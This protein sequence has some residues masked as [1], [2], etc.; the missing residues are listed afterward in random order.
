MPTPIIPTCFATVRMVDLD[1]RHTHH[2]IFEESLQF[3]KDHKEK[4][5]FSTVHGRRLMAY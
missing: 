1:G 3:I 5:L 2:S 4:L